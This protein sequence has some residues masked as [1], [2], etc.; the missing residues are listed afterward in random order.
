VS[1]LAQRLHEPLAE[2]DDPLSWEGL[3]ATVRKYA[4]ALPLREA[5]DLSSFADLLDGFGELETN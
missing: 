5:E 1:C 4:Q 3:A 2:I